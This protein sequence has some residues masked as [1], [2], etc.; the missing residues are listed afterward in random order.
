MNPACKSREKLQAVRK[1]LRQMKKQSQTQY[2]TVNSG[3]LCEKPPIP[4]FMM[5]F[6]DKVNLLFI[7]HTCV[8]CSMNTVEKSNERLV[9]NNYDLNL[10]R[11]SNL[12]DMNF[13]PDFKNRY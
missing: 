12:S 4:D 2:T 3:E 8:M 1:Q 9:R 10:L 11:F 6:K 7:K 5:N 13:I